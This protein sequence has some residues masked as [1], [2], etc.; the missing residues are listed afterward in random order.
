MTKIELLRGGNRARGDTR[1]ARGSPQ[2]GCGFRTAAAIL[3]TTQVAKEKERARDEGKGEEQWRESKRDRSCGGS[4]GDHL[5]WSAIA[6]TE[7]SDSPFDMR[8]GL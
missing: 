3:E 6:A 4:G 7:R 5:T 2:R 8:T 1:R